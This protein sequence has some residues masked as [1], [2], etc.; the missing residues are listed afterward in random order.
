[1]GAGLRRGREKGDTLQE[2][3]ESGVSFQNFPAKKE[4]KWSSGFK[5]DLLSFT[6]CLYQVRVI[7]VFSFP[8]V[9]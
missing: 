1:M 9:D 7:A 8:V 4:E 5:H 3:T 2:G 6:G